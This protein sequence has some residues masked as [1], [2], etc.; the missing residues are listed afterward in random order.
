MAISSIIPLCTFTPPLT[1]LLTNAQGELEVVT[2]KGTGKGVAATAE[3]DVVERL[4]FLLLALDLPAAPLFK[5]TLEKNI[6]PQVI[7]LRG[8]ED[9]MS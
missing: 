7:S 1:A 9:R 5:D 6:I 4:P 2:E 3:A 8:G